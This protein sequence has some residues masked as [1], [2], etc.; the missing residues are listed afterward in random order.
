M[1]LALIGKNLF[2]LVGIAMPEPIK[3]KKS[4]IHKECTH[5]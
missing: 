4:D 1:A 3:K 2:F 5:V